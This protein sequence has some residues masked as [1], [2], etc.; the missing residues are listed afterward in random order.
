MRSGESLEKFR[1]QRLLAFRA[2]KVASLLLTA[3]A[4]SLLGV[5]AVHAQ[6]GGKKVKPK[7]TIPAGSTAVTLPDAMKVPTSPKVPTTFEGLFAERDK[8]ALDALGYLRCLQVT[9]S[10]IQS[11]RLGQVPREWLMT[12]VKQESEWRGVF[13]EL[14][15][16]APGI[17]VQRQF[18]LRGGGMPVD[19]AIDTATVA[20]ITRAMLR[21]LA[22]PLPGK[23]SYEFMPVPLM[24]GTYIEVWFLP[25]PSN[26]Q[27]AVVGGDSLIQMSADGVRELGHARS[28]PPI[29]TISVSGGQ[30]LS[31]ASVEE[32]IPQLSELMLAHL[33]LSIAPEVRVLTQQ[34]E[35]IFK[36]GTLNVQHVQR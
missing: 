12:C 16:D 8:R 11:G 24:Q 21:G 31:I 14:T 10:A 18:A 35:S 15:Q 9:L 32:R 27:R 4:A 28:A 5:S 36:R 25:V 20:G 6:S 7:P 1:V 17:R 2:S 34:Y 30:T 23:G 3:V 22:A 26:P 29:R 33:A 13:S 19:D